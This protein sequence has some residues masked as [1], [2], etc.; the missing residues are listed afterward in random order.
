MQS[1]SN[2]VVN[3]AIAASYERTYRT[4]AT[5]TGKFMVLLDPISNTDN[6]HTVN[7]QFVGLRMGGPC[8]WLIM[9]R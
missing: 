9:H 2:F 7:T 5:P 4:T 1:A 8:V 6:A 3:D